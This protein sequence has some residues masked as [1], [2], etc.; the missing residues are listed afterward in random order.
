[1][2][3][4]MVQNTPQFSGNFAAGSGLMAAPVM[5]ESVGVFRMMSR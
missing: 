5:A 4:S 3:V 1:M 2:A